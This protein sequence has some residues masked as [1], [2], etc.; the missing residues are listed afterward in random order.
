VVVLV[1]VVV[2][3]VPAPGPLE[4]LMITFEPLSTSLPAGG[5][6]AKTEPCGRVDGAFWICGTRPAAVSFCTAAF[7]SSP[8]TDGTATG[9][10]PVDT[11]MV[12]TDPFRAVTPGSGA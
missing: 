3:V 5:F 6:C 1:V 10:S 2:V 7:C 4:T 9:F 11:L 12:T 8:T